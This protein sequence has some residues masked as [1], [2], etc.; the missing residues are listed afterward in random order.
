MLVIKSFLEQ[1]GHFDAATDTYIL[2]A[3]T[4]SWIT[5]I[6]VVG[7]FVGAASAYY[8]GDTI[9]RKKGLYISSSAVVIGTLLQ[10][11]PTYIGTLAV[12]RLLVGMLLIAT[13]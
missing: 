8:V 7:E 3:S 9:G 13:M 5:S 1:Y 2:S 12:G 11:I 6:I 4:Q 10:T